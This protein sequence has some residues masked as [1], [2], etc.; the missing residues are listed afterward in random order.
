MEKIKEKSTL[1][2]FDVLRLAAE[3]SAEESRIGKIYQLS[4]DMLKMQLNFRLQGKKELVFEAGKRLHLTS[5][6]YPSPETP[7]TFAL[8]LRKY[9]QNAAVE[10][11]Y[12]KNFDRIVV[13]EAAKG[14][15]RYK[16]IFELF[17]DGNCILTDEK[18]RIITLLKPGKFKERALLGGE[19][20]SFPS[21]KLNPFLIA[22]EEL[23]ENSKGEKIVKFL[24]TSLGFGGMYAEEA[25]L[26]AGIDK[27]KEKIEKEE[28]EKLIRAINEIKELALSSS[29]VVIY[30]SGA[31]VDAAPFLLEIYRIQGKEK[32]EFASL[33]AALDEYFT[34]KEFERKLGGAEQEQKNKL[35]KLKI[36]LREQAK[37][38][39]KL[40]KEELQSRKAGD[41]IQ[42]NLFKIDGI[43]AE[44]IKK[45]E[46]G[47]ALI[48]M[49]GSKLRI[50]LKL[51]AAKNADTYYQESK[52]AK[53]KIKGLKPSIEKT[54]KEIKAVLSSIKEK[55]FELP[56]QKLEAKIRAKKEKEWYETFRWFKTSDGFLVIAGRDAST[57][58]IVVKKHLEK[59]DVFVHG[60]VYGAPVAVV[61]NVVKRGEREREGEEKT[62][63]ISRSS[64]REACE[65][66]AAYSRAWK[67]RIYALDVYWVYPEQV[68][69][70]P[71]HGE[72]LGKGAFV[73]RG[74]RSWER[75]V[76]EIGVGV[77]ISE[78]AGEAKI[79]SGAKSAVQKN[80]LCSA[81]LVPGAKKSRET[82]EEIKQI[83]LK[84]CR[85][86]DK[87]KIE[88]ISLEEIQHVLPTGEHEIKI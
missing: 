61:K 10:R 81:V 1:S 55:K 58:E 46:K 80:A 29:P 75:V 44:K 62:E 19:M 4:K 53:E 30:E 24:A 76:L 52:K 70:T 6:V 15:E 64:I 7:T 12:Q 68:S 35:E 5:Y 36:R 8:T 69:K 32:K 74:K 51:N 22:P 47:E 37:N 45:K 49:G 63:V 65:F 39:K 57:N 28:A 31:Q 72:Y 40:K 42:S 14:E 88:K 73:I 41:M 84:S 3:L 27:T 83:F 21:P 78:E 33:N 50:S 25:C 17:N 67:E 9:L 16:L 26:R 86:G 43:I 38:L 18:H 23:A 66:A 71:E 85:E 11:I 59:N 20:Y 54:K 60:D 87:D 48:E 79:I 2:S 82:A 56:A 13:L 34:K 77:L